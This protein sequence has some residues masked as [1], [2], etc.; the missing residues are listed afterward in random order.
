MARKISVLLSLLILCLCTGCFKY[1]FLEGDK[2]RAAII[3]E[4]S[5]AYFS[6]LGKQEIAALSD[7]EVRDSAIDLQRDVLRDLFQSYVKNFT[8]E[9]ISVIRKLAREVDDEVKDIWPEFSELKWK[10]VKVDNRYCNGFL[11]T[12]E[13]FIVMPEKITGLS[14]LKGRFL[15]KRLL[16]HEKIHVLQRKH[17]QAFEKFYGMHWGFK[18]TA[19]IQSVESLIK[20]KVNNPD[21]LDLVFVTPIGDKWWWARTLFKAGEKNPKMGRDFENYFVQVSMQGKAASLVLKDDQ[22]ILR[23]MKDD[24]YEKRFHPYAF[25]RG[26]DHPHEIFAYSFEILMNYAKGQTFDSASSEKFLDNLHLAFK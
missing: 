3:S 18:K 6:V 11:H 26:G 10:F 17:P 16:L 24:V 19:T 23:P 14:L 21:A 1:D 13:D 5:E 9:E 12:R 25:R 8:D 2:A 22:P 4:D 20:R 7:R 15:L